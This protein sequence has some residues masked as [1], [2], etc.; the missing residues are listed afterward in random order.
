MLSR[1]IGDYAPSPSRPCA[2]SCEGLRVKEVPTGLHAWRA[3]S[4]FRPP[5]GRFCPIELHLSPLN[6]SLEGMLCRPNA[7]P[8]WEGRRQASINC[9]RPSCCSS[10]EQAAFTTRHH[11]QS[12][13]RRFEA[14]DPVDSPN[15]NATAPRRAIL[16]PPLDSLNAEPSA[17]AS[18]GRPA[19]W[20]P[21]HQRHIP[22][23]LAMMAEPFY[24]VRRQAEATR[25]P[26]YPG[27]N[28]ARDVHLSWLGP[29]VALTS[30]GGISAI[31]RTSEA[32]L[33]CWLGILDVQYRQALIERPTADLREHRR[34]VQARIVA[35]MTAAATT[36]GKRQGAHNR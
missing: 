22:L 28:T 21:L 25:T 27:N 14:G 24:S 12:V 36:L 34:R 3:D 5:V 15:W 20:E 32:A 13:Y 9:G 29:Q 17:K 11:S 10:A 19:H 33:C 30:G 2:R 16:S 6:E 8:Y 18:P 7:A 4:L 35:P 23:E 31:G 26:G 1:A